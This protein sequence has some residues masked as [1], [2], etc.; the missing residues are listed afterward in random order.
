MADILLL[1][2]I[3]GDSGSLVV[4]T[5]TSQAYGHVIATGPEGIVYVVPLQS[6][7]QQVRAFFSTTDVRLADPLKVLAELAVFYI[8]NKQMHCA[9]A[10]LLA[11]VDL[12]QQLC[13]TRKW[14][15][16]VH[17]I[18]TCAARSTLLE[19]SLNKLRATHVGRHLLT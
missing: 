6:T 8:N 18:E 2:I 12:V 16:L 14:Q 3:D 15:Q 1:E 10:S 17:W 9:S 11:L 13:D 5:S 19:A 4:D 7:L